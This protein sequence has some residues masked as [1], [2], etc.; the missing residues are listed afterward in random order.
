M[1][2]TKKSLSASQAKELNRKLN[3]KEYMIE[4]PQKSVFPLLRIVHILNH[5]YCTV[6]LN[7]KSKCKFCLQRSARKLSHIFGK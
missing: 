1:M 2:T 3:N 6:Q 5:L 4:K 7:F